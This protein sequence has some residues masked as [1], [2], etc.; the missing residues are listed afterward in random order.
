MTGHSADNIKVGKAVNGV[1]TGYTSDEDCYRFI[2]TKAQYINFS[3]AHEK[4][5]DAG[6][7]WY[8]TLYNANGKRVS[9]KDDDHIY[10]YAGSTYTESK[11]V[12]LSK[13]T[14]YLKVQA[15]AKMRWKKN[16]RSVLIKLRTEKQA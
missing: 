12:K 16:T 13:G 5:N 7:S 4:I 6:R 14:Y 9:R 10:S 8:V 3:L 11:A 1:I 15:F 2:L